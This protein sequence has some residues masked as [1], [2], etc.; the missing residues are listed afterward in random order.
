[1]DVS[2]LLLLNPKNAGA[3]VKE[4]RTL[5][6]LTQKE[7]ELKC[8]F[9]SGFIGKLERGELWRI[10]VPDANELEFVLRKFKRRNFEALANCVLQTSESKLDKSQESASKKSVPAFST[11]DSIPRNQSTVTPF[12]GSA[13]KQPAPINEEKIKTSMIFEAIWRMALFVGVLLVIGTWIFS[14]GD[15]GEQSPAWIPDS[16]KD[17]PNAFMTTPSL[18]EPNY[19]QEIQ[20]AYN[21]INCDGFDDSLPGQPNFQPA[22]NPGFD[23]DGDGL[24]NN[25]DTDV[26]G[27]G[28]PN[29]LD[30]FSDP[31]EIGG[32]SS[33]GCPV[34][35]LNC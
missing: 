26:N 1:M 24:P 4:Q 32:L 12:P 27:D 21:D 17:S 18:P 16:S 19:E 33:F 28:I 14:L 31:F 2:Y 35:Q 5:Q 8:N 10:A 30:V 20:C 15:S 13:A 22:P 29:G 7:L 23:F 34:G 11:S 3:Y 9:P 6:G 25:A